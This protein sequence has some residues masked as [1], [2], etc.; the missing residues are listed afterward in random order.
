[1]YIAGCMRGWL[2][3]YSRAAELYALCSVGTDSSQCASNQCNVSALVLVAKS[4]KLAIYCNSIMRISFL[5]FD[6]ARNPSKFL[7]LVAI[8]VH[9]SQYFFHQIFQ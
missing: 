7:Q 8:V 6:I 4:Q 3:T 9:V 1:M 2:D 5:T